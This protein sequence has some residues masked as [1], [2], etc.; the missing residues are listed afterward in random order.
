MNKRWSLQAEWRLGYTAEH[1]Q[2]V[3][4]HFG[5]YLGKMQWWF[6]YAGIDWRS[7]EMHMGDP[8]DNLFG[9]VN[10]K[11]GRS[12]LCAGVQYTLPLLFVLDGRVDTDG[13][14][15]AQ[16]MREDIPLTPRLRLDLMGNSDLEHM[17]RLRYVL[18]K[19]WALSTHY[20]SDMG[21]GVGLTIIY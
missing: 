13:R 10:T 16:L 6:P 12:V 19:S 3:E 15:R 21:W 20:D 14:L 2:E 1:G 4:T 7:R 9:Q 5:R 8:E 17:E 18:D 11:D